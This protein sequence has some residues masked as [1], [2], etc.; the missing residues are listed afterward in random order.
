MPARQLTPSP[1]IVVCERI[2]TF[3]A[4]APLGMQDPPQPILTDGNGA[5]L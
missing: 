3:D 4:V 2:Q 1:S 5:W